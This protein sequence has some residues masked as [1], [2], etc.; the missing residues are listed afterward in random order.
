MPAYEFRCIHCG[1]AKE[2]TV[3]MAERDASQV[4]GCGY[5]MKRVPSFGGFSFKGGL[6]SNAGRDP[7]KVWR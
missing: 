4:C 2:A 6:P 5:A 7:M 1:Y 3:P